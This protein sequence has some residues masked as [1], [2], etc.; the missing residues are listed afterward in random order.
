MSRLRSLPLVAATA[1]AAAAF[2]VSGCKED[3][4]VDTAAISASL[5]TMTTRDVETLISD[6]GIVRYRIT[7]PVW[8]VYDD[9]DTPVWKFPQGVEL[10]KFNTLFSH[11]A[12]VRADSATYFKTSQTWRLDGRVNISNVKGERFLTEQLFWD[13]REHKLYSDSF[14]HIER[15]DRVLEGYGFDSDERL[16]RYTIRRV[17]GIFPSIVSHSKEGS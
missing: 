3:D 4:P 8:Y 6:S 5:P 13:Q 11:D 15:P 12:T 17:S 7:T 9:I 16:S 1:F 2:A 10:E 14:I